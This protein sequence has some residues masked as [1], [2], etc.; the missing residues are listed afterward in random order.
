MQTRN[1]Y[2]I[3]ATLAYRVQLTAPL[4][5]LKVALFRAPAQ[6][7]S[8]PITSFEMHLMRVNERSKA[9]WWILMRS[10]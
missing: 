8:R 7:R 2:Q 3:F 1:L 6:R 5:S 4:R 9:Q 10:F